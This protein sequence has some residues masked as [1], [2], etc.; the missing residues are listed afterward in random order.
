MNKVVSILMGTIIAA[1]SMSSQAQN[2][3]IRVRGVAGNISSERYGDLET[4][5]A[6]V[7]QSNIESDVLALQEFP[8]RMAGTENADLS[9]AWLVDRLADIGYDAVLDSFDTGGGIYGCNVYACLVGQSHPEYYIIVG[10]HRDSWPGS[11][12]ANDNATSMAGFL[13]M[14][15]ILKDI[16]TQV[17]F[18]F[19]F[20]DAKEMNRR[21]GS[22]HHAYQA[23]IDEDNLII[24]LNMDV[25]GY[26]F[27]PDVRLYHYPDDTY[28]LLYQSLASSLSTVDMR[29]LPSGVAT[30]YDNEPFQRYGFKT[31]TAR[32][33]VLSPHNHTATDSAIYVD[34]DYATRITR[35]LLATAIVID[36]EYLVGEPGLYISYPNGEPHSILPETENNF[37][38]KI[39]GIAGGSVVPGSV[40]FNYKVGDNP[41]ENS[42]AMTYV[43]NDLYTVNIPEF[44]C[45]AGNLKYYVSAQENGGTIFNFPDPS[46]PGRLNLSTEST[47][48]F[49]DDM[50][51]ENGWTFSNTQW[52]IG[53]P[54][55][56]GGD[57]VSGYSPWNCLNYNI[58]GT[59]A[60][61]LTEEYA[62]SPAI[63]CS[64]YSNIILT[65]KRWL[66]VDNPEFDH[67]RVKVSNDGANW[68]TV[69]ENS[70]KHYS[71][72]WKDEIIDISSVA[73]NQSTVYIRF[74]MGPTDAETEY[75]GWNIDDLELFSYGCV[76]SWICGDVDGNPGINILDIVFLIN[77]IYKGG[78][79]AE[80][81]DAMEINGDTF[82]NILDI[83]YLINNIYKG[84]PEP[85]CS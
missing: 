16:G 34:Y 37:V 68:T 3:E 70:A 71:G 12:G 63:D 61:N 31:L 4:I 67:A 27:S 52:N 59:Y 2:Q 72:F 28:A 54:M 32:E 45:S 1:F 39:Q 23:L 9:R 25:I 10:G 5:T 15:R 29:G 21:L 35:G 84:G 43:D 44:Q 82:I 77:Y 50:E 13:E 20:Y 8:S 76:G 79:A 65:Y 74:V 38:I 85:L 78:P 47:S 42:A 62:T 57:P 60:S 24:M 41:A 58:F 55:G 30:Y 22:Q 26:S 6:Q 17:T 80:P 64:E 83:V 81:M 49:F 14:A 40:M 7:S 48:I 53:K 46:E 73:K 56:V 36:D 33:A 69:W 18:I 19:A 75:C 51:S 66:G 11:P